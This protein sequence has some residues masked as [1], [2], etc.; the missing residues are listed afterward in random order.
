MGLYQMA[1][2]SCMESI[3]YFQGQ[4]LIK[5]CIAVNLGC[6]FTLGIYIHYQNFYVTIVNFHFLI[7]V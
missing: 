1:T 4:E 3:Y 6:P 2:H 5:S 7:H